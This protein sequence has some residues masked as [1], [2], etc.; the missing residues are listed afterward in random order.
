MAKPD[1]APGVVVDVK[2]VGPAGTKVRSERVEIA[3]G[4]DDDAL[5]VFMQLLE[6]AEATKKHEDA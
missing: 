1:F 3:C 4:S 5:A 6:S 2:Q